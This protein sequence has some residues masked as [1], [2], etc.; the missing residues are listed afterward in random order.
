ML[1]KLTIFRINTVNLA[2]IFAA[3]PVTVIVRPYLIHW[4]I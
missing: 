2:A 1:N 3:V 4:G